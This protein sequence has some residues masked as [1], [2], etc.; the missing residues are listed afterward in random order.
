MATTPMAFVVALDKNTQHRGKVR[1]KGLPP[2][3]QYEQGLHDAT[4][5][6]CEGGFATRWGQSGS[7][8]FAPRLRSAVGAGG[9]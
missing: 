7:G 8:R 5:I 3:G 4:G 6:P 1:W 2:V 9:R